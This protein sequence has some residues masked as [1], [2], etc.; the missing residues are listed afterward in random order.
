M[1]VAGSEGAISSAGPDQ[2]HQQV[3]LTTA[4]GV[5]R[6]KLVGSWFPDGFHGTMGELLSAIEE[7]REPMNSAEQPRQPGALLRRGRQRRA[8]QAGRAR[9]RAE[10]A[11]VEFRG[12]LAILIGDNT[13][14]ST[15][16]PLPLLVYCASSIEPAMMP[17]S[18][19]YQ[20]ETGTPIKLETGASGPLVEAIKRAKRGDLFVPASE[21]PFL[22]RLRQDGTVT[23]VIPLAALHLVLAVQRGSTAA[24]ITLS[25]LLAGRHRYAI[26]HEESA[27][28]L[29]TLAALAP[30]GSWQ[31]FAEGAEAILTNVTE[32]AAAIRDGGDVDCGIVWDATAR[33]IR[34]GDNRASRARHSSN[35]HRCRRPGDEPR[36]CGRTTVCRLSRRAGQR[37]RILQDAG[38]RGSRRVAACWVTHSPL[39]AEIQHAAIS[40]S[41]CVPALRW[42]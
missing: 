30:L 42:M 18:A 17:I 38:L 3:E 21:K 25:D 36:W 8:R 22:D 13:M 1:F 28:G 35:Y 7:K 41:K 11:D 5:A 10:V 26:A 9:H 23:D 33:P 15:K 27:A 6:P 14:S 32:V 2:D 20:R 29:A 16:D 39:I 19:A 12:H 34:S 4:A 40:G 24:A 31:Q 37:T